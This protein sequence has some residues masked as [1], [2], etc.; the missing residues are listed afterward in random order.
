MPAESHAPSPRGLLC[1]A[2]AGA[3]AGVIAATFVCPLDVIKTRFQVHGLPQL[4]NG[5]IKGKSFDLKG[6][7]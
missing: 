4:G 1:N 5:N 3:A 2:G 7:I 6:I